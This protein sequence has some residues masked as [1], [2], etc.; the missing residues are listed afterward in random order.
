MA[1]GLYRQ[2]SLLP[3]GFEGRQ[4]G[5]EDQVLRG[6]GESVEMMPRWTLPRGLMEVLSP[7]PRRGDQG[8]SAHHVN[9][10][11]LWTAC[12]VHSPAGFIQQQD[13]SSALINKGH[14]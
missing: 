3:P 11:R 7:G 13:F 14:K 2:A 12:P 10:S 1:G 9:Q 8:R 6:E 4:G 5:R